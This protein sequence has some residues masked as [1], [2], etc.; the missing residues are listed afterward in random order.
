LWSG[1]C[2]QCLTTS[3]RD[4]ESDLAIRLVVFDLQSEAQTFQ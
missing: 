3:V 1:A 4:E 2:H